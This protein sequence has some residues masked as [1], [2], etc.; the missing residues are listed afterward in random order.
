MPSVLPAFEVVKI[1]GVVAPLVPLFTDVALEFGKLLPPT[2]VFGVPVTIGLGVLGLGGMPVKLFGVL[3]FL[4]GGAG[5]E[6]GGKPNGVPGLSRG[7]ECVESVLAGRG[8]STVTAVTLRS[9]RFSVSAVG[10]CVPLNRLVAD[11]TGVLKKRKPYVQFA[12]R[13]N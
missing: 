2:T 10:E 7:M 1:L 12:H 5:L 4:T 11:V 3:V 8:T 9:G 6:Q 13:D